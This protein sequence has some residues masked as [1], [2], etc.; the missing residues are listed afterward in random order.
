MSFAT[1]TLVSN[2]TA[3]AQAKDLNI[4]EVVD[5][6]PCILGPAGLGWIGL[7]LNDAGDNIRCLSSSEWP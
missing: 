3:K 2:A 7:Y 6:E 1:M 4:L 5:C